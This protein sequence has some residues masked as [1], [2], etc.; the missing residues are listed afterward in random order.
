VYYL[1]GSCL[2]LVVECQL[3][4]ADC[5]L[6][7]VA[8]KWLFLVPDCGVLVVGCWLLIGDGGGGGCCR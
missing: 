3:S 4:S 7:G 2:L 8:V 6:L 1:G 5:W